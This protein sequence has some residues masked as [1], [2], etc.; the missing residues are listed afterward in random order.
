M[1][2]WVGVCRVGERVCESAV[3]V[4][5]RESVGTILGTGWRRERV[6]EERGVLFGNAM[7]HACGGGQVPR[8][9]QCTPDSGKYNTAYTSDKVLGPLQQRWCHG[10]YPDTDRISEMINVPKT[11]RCNEAS[12]RVQN[13]WFMRDSCKLR[14]LFTHSW[15]TRCHSCNNLSLPYVTT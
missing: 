8:C 6:N 9:K 1:G 10:S 11:C 2:V 12:A 4:S 14:D 7:I 3:V 5:D 15:E 13:A